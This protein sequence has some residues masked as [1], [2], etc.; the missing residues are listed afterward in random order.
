MYKRQVKRGIICTESLEHLGGVAGSLAR[1]ADGVYE[2]LLPEQRAAAE[3]LLTRLV[4]I[5]GTRTTRNEEELL[6]NDPAERATLDALVRARLVVARRLG[7]DTNAYEPVSYTHLLNISSLAA[8]IA[9][10]S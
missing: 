9:P 6:S 10:P 4:R 1:Y 8:W 5:D 3:R 2:H 7:V